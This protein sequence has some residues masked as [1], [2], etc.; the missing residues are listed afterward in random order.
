MVFY[1][2]FRVPQGQ[3]AT[4][5]RNVKVLVSIKNQVYYGADFAFNLIR[6]AEQMGVILAEV[7]ATFNALQG[8]AGFITEVMGNFPDTDRKFLVAVRFI[9]INPHMMRAVHRT[10]NKGFSVY[11]HGREH[12]VFIMCPVT[13]GLIQVYGANARGHN[14]LVAQQTFF[15]LNVSFQFL[16]NGI[17]FREEHGKA[18]AYQVICHEE[19]HFFA[20]LAVVSGF[21]FFYLLQVFIQFCL[22]GKGHA[23][24]AGQHLIVGVIPPI[25]AGLLG[26]LECL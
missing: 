5:I 19:A 8:T 16:P 13:G 25:S 24:D 14:V 26:Q 10:Q 3:N 17:S 22:G 12:I 20:D 15:F 7:T 21:G 1:G 6:G 2:V 23:V 18:A 11:F 9:G 4:V